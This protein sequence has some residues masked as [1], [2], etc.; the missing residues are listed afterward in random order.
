LTG[1]FHLAVTL[2]SIKIQVY[3]PHR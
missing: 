3:L 2:R 1:T